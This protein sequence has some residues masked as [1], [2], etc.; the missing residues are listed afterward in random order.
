MR[1]L[2]RTILV[3]AVISGGVAAAYKPVTE[4]LKKRK[5]P[6]YRTK[7]VDMGR[8]R[9]TVNAT[10]TVKPK[11]SIL[12]GSF[13]SGPITELSVEFNQD[14]KKDEILAVIDPKLFA[15]AVDRDNAA[16]DSRE[17]EVRRVTAQ[18][19][20][21]KRDENRA[22]ML[23]KEDEGYISDAE[24]DRLKYNKQSLEA[25]LDL[26]SAAVKQA[27]SSLAR[28][29][30][31]LDYTRIKAP[32]D[33]T[34]IDRK[35]DP[36]QT[37][38]STFQTPELFELGIDMREEMHVYALVDEADIGLIRDAS[39]T[40]QPVRFRVDA[41]RDELFNGIIKEIR[42]SSSET[43][44]VVTYPVVVAAA[45]PELKLMP[46]MT[47]NITF[48]IEEKEDV[49]RIPW[50]ALRF[51]PKP[52]YVREEDRQL[53]EG[54]GD[55]DD[56]DENLSLDD[57]SAGEQVEASRKRLQRH[58]WVQDGDKLKAVD[59]FLGISDYRYAELVEGDIEVGMKLVTGVETKKRG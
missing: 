38:A 27:R 59:V 29:E 8:I 20:Q 37:L 47:A 54:R 22:L 43:Q 1:L 5:Q 44:N 52:E 4:F 19:E 9:F 46:G 13:V 15:A 3:L 18:L 53:L 39:S 55:D 48:Q 56:D 58:V 42:M 34:I 16:L 6:V 26:A 36:G 12:I 14:V 41:Y 33:G 32:E 21:A 2:I 45:N 51:Y 24:L 25:Q 31:E 23:H 11:R 17:A 7:T 50:A 57:A 30:T 40:G 28:S 49:V 10:G 35:I